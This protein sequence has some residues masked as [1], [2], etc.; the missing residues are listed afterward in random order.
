MFRLFFKRWLHGGKQGLVLHCFPG[1]P[2]QL[3]NG[4]C[5]KSFC[6]SLFR[7]Q[8]A[9][10]HGHDILGGPVPRPAGKSLFNLKQNGKTVSRPL[11]EILGFLTAF[12][13]E[14]APESQ[15]CGPR[16]TPLSFTL[17]A[18]A[19]AL[20]V[21]GNHFNSFTSLPRPCVIWLLLTSPASFLTGS[22]G[23]QYRGYI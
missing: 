11:T 19:Q 4:F 22:R 15:I 20:T 1:I 17:W 8:I 23:T 6:G 12:W 2:Q 3:L 10:S 14:K 13:W 18:E 7:I 5:S 9:F 16:H 21:G